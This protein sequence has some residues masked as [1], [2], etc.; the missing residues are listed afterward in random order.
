MTSTLG[1]KLRDAIEAAEARKAMAE[2][3]QTT[4][5]TAPSMTKSKVSVSEAVFNMVR[6]NPGQTKAG[7]ATLMEAQG[8]KNTTVVSMLSIMLR[9]GIIRIENKALFAVGDKYKSRVAFNRGLSKKCK[10]TKAEPKKEVRV[11]RRPKFGTE[12][13]GLVLTDMGEGNARWVKQ[14]EPDKGFDV[15]ALIDSLTLRQAMVLRK[16]L[17][18]MWLGDRP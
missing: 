3:E 17:N 11:I 4:E 15:D 10:V 18:D 8:Y 6:D 5:S 14:P 13:G 16:R 2:W 7:I 1:Q 9:Y 12:V